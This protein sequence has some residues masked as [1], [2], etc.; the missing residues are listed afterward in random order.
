[1]QRPTELAA[2]ALVVQ[3]RGDIDGVGIG[4]D[5]CIE[6]RIKPVDTLQVGQRKRAAGKCARSHKGLEL[7]DCRFKPGR[8][9]IGICRAAWSGPQQRA[10]PCG[11]E[12]RST[13]GAR[14]QECSPADAALR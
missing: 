11:Q 7:R 12:G 10:P 9:F 14:T 5:D 6:Q 4:L 3:L 2:S 13:E 8:V 1:M